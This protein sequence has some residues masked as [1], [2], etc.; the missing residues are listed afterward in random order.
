MLRFRHVDRVDFRKKTKPNNLDSGMHDRKW[1]KSAGVRLMISIFVETPLLHPTHT[2]FRGFCKWPAAD[3]ANTSG[4][5]DAA[6]TTRYYYYLLLCLFCELNSDWVCSHGYNLPIYQA[7]I[8]YIY[9]QMTEI[10]YFY[11][12]RVC[13]RDRSS[14]V[15]QPFFL[16]LC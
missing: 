13:T 6:P 5:K 15:R 11:I 9:L 3:R 1:R 4:V 8:I 2:R 14:V 12:L 16:Y 10:Q 7:H